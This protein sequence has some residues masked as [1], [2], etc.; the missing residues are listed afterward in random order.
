[1]AATHTPVHDDNL[2]AAQEPFGTDAEV[3]GGVFTLTM[4]AEKNNLKEQRQRL[5]RIENI[6]VDRANALRQA[7]EGQDLGTKLTAQA[8][9][10][11][12]CAEYRAAVLNLFDLE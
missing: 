7:L 10:D 1:M 6:C 4:M 8:N 9:F 12:A 11:R 2:D 3:V 5:T